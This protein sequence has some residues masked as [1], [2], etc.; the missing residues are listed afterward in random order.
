MKSRALALC[1]ALFLIGIAPVPSGAEVPRTISFEGTLTTPE[2]VPVPDGSQTV[3]ASLY[4]SASGGATLWTGTYTVNTV[5]GAFRISLGDPAVQPFPP[6]LRFDIPYWLGLKVG[7]DPEM[8]PRVPLQSAPY[9]LNVPSNLFWSLRGNAGTA[10]GASFLGTTDNQPLELRANNQRVMRYEPGGEGPNIIGGFSGNWTKPGENVITISGGGISGA[11]NRVIRLGGTIGG[12]ANNYAGTEHPEAEVWGYDTIGGGWENRAH[13][14]YATVAG[15]QGNIAG[16]D[17]ATV[18]GGGGNQALG[19]GSAALGGVSNTASA[20]NATTV[21]GYHNI[22]AAP[23]AFAAGVRA[24]ALHWGAWVWRDMS[25]PDVP[26]QSTG[27]NQFLLRA[28][29]GVGINTNAPAY[30]L[31]VAGPVRARSIGFV[32]PDGTVQNTAAATGFAGWSLTGNA[33]TTPGTQFLGTTDNQALEVKVNGARALRVEPTTGAANLVGGL[34]ANSV[35]AGAVGVAICGGGGP[36]GSSNNAYDSYATVAGGANNK[37]GTNDGNVTNATYAT[38]G[39]GTGNTASGQQSTV[40]GGAGNTASGT[41]AMVPGG[42]ANTAAGAMSFAAG[43]RARANH[44]GSFVWADSTNADFASTAANQ[45]LVRASGNVGVNVTDPAATVDVGGPV[46]SRAGGFVFPDG[47]TQSSAALLPGSAA[48]GDLTGAYPAP[49]IAANAVTSAKLAANSVTTTHLATGSVTSSKI[50]AGAVLDGHIDTVSWGKITGEPTSFP[51]NGPAGGSLAGTYPNP[52]LAAGAVGTL[53]LASYSVTEAKLAAAS[54][55]TAKIAD[56][57]ITAE[58]LA[59]GAAGVTVIS[60]TCPVD[61]PAAHAL[62]IV[63]VEVSV[64]GV[65]LGDTVTLSPSDG[66]EP[67]YWMIS[68]FVSA[69]GKVTVRGFNTNTVSEDPASENYRFIIFH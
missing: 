24:E 5:K 59:P 37:A 39:G 15:G 11:T 46:R 1:G 60:A 22:A 17:R 9:A 54:V 35:A 27:D 4:D 67:K 44:D 63:E 10:D 36:M 34:A 32:F 49:T 6:S 18:A 65:S 48:G 29:G 26:F 41:N 45:F 19:G 14:G 56:G 25:E 40:G 12:G 69:A 61:L 58:K 51:P 52:G 57:A 31:D 50:A 66:S 55:T 68:A 47:T 8:T 16:N 64:P 33:G 13:G 62:G 38:V 23:G 42:F 7:G 20:G 43:R 2:G 21:G 30:T 3:V 53:Q 28:A